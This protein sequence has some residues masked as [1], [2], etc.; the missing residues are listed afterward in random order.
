MQFL[1]ILTILMLNIFKL[2]L[3]QTWN[4]IFHDEF[5]GNELDTTK[6][7][8]TRHQSHTPPYELEIYE[9]ENVYL[10]NGMLVLETKYQPTTK[11]GVTYP[12]TSGVVTSENK[13]SHSYGKFEIRAKLP[14]P[15]FKHLWPAIWLQKQS[16]QCYQE[17]D[18]MEQWV[19]RDANHLVTSYHWNPSNSTSHG[20]APIFSKSIGYYPPIGQTIDFSK[21]FHIWQL[22]WNKTEIAFWIDDHFITKLIKEDAPKQMPY[23][24]GYIIFNTA[25]CGADYC[26]GTSGIPRNIT[27]YFY[28]DYVRVYEYED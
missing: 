14:T 7:S 15:K 26:G 3:S 27:G 25:V 23:E 19:G 12:Y 5:D 22:I 1:T 11:S 2:S 10:K 8:N 16:G 21:D 6:W 24:P 20:C 4:L 17:I 9:P 13:F 18:I 28:I